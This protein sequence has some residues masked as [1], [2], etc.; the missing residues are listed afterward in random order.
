[1]IAKVFR[2]IGFAEELGSG[3]RNL[4]KLVPLYSGKNVKPKIIDGDVFKVYIP[5]SE[6]II[7]DPVNDPV[8]KRQNKILTIIRENPKI[9]AV[10]LAKQL[11]VSEKT[12]KRDLQFLR[13]NNL[14]EH[15]GSDKKGYWKV[16]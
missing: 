16:K 2:E 15:L 6:K 9:T 12:I 14:I 5:L 3:T 7:N 10:E 4:Y 1:M 13:E 8:K 11:N